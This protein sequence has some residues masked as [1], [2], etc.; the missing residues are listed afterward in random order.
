VTLLIFRP[1][2]S[3][4][5]QLFHPDWSAAKWR[6]LLFLFCPSNL[7]A[8]NKSHHPPL[9]IPTRIPATKHRT[10]PR[11][12]CINATNLNRN[13]GER[14]EGSA[15]CPGSRTEV[16]VPLVL[17]QNR[18]PERS[19]SQIHR[20]TQR[21]WRGVE[22]PR[23]AYLTHAARNF[24]TTEAR[25]IA[26]AAIRTCSRPPIRTSWLGCQDQRRWA[27]RIQFARIGKSGSF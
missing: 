27:R 6:D 21:L 4:F 14:R 12:K 22:G 23:G 1:K 16:S 18:H 13:P 2:R 8:S 20:L 7:T 15:L 26:C 9:V 11:V 17:P 10:G 25:Q 3:S 19:A 5:K 24:S